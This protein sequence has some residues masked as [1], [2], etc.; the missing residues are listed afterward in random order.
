[1]ICAA[2]LKTQV[3]CSGKAKYCIYYDNQ[4]HLVCHKHT[5]STAN[6]VLPDTY[7]SI[8]DIPSLMRASVF[9]SDNDDRVDDDIAQSCLASLNEIGN[10][11]IKVSERL[12]PLLG[13][14][15]FKTNMNGWILEISMHPER[16]NDLQI[17]DCVQNKIQQHGLDLFMPIYKTA[18]GVRMSKLKD[19][20]HYAQLR[21]S[22]YPFDMMIWTDAKVCE[23]V[24]HMC[25][26]LETLH[27]NR[28]CHGN[29]NNGTIGFLE[30]DD[31]TS[32]R[33]TSSTEITL[34]RDMY[35]RY[36]P[37]T[38]ALV[39]TTNH[40]Y[41]CI[42]ASMHNTTSRYDDFESL[43]YLMLDL[44]GTIL[45]WSNIQ[46][47]RRMLQAKKDFISN[48][49]VF[50]SD[51][52]SVDVIS[53]LCEMINMGAFDSMPDYKVLTPLFKRVALYQ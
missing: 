8:N 14:D 4:Y 52:R 42:R 40:K 25:G 24:E 10:L 28:I 32:A 45:P 38:Q 20:C 17:A 3:P 51:H 49:E 18:T 37:E 19:K 16:M 11:D 44:Q 35:G 6:A 9:Y 41:A 22:Y 46:S 34:W 23:F 39:K 21:K 12:P 1:M 27:N 47:A 26:L 30:A 5:L 29:L 43:L 50:V 53:Q 33:L 31:P 48:P 15:R 2:L 7:R 13:M 36:I